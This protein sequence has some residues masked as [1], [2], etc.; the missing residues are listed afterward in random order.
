MFEGITYFQP[1]GERNMNIVTWENISA[2]LQVNANKIRRSQNIGGAWPGA[3]IVETINDAK[4]FVKFKI[5]PL[6]DPLNSTIIV[7][8]NK[9]G[10][11]AAN[12]EYSFS[13]YFSQDEVFA[14]EN[15]D[16]GGYIGIPLIE[17]A[18]FRLKMLD[19]DVEYQVKNPCSTDFETFV[20]SSLLANPSDVYTINVTIKTVS[21]GLHILGL[22]S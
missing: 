18:E 4:G 8:V 2:N 15:G 13:F 7:G 16:L 22:S 19:G 10:R 3:N 20:T 14:Y 17:G 9:N 12:D 1:Q 11:V 21:D 6:V 5:K